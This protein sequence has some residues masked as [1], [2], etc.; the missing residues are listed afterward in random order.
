[1][2]QVRLVRKEPPESRAATVSGGI[3]AL[4]DKVGIQEWRGPR[5]QEDQQE[6]RAHPDPPD[7][8]ATQ[9]CC[10]PLTIEYR[11]PP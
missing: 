10:M 5:E 1:M 4:Q 7:L 2:F 3:L 8:K 11:T 6:A 9:V